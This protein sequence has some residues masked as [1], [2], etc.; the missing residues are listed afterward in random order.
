M[1]YKF[2]FRAQ[3]IKR[4]V[5]VFRNYILTSPWN[6]QTFWFSKGFC[7][8]KYQL[9]LFENWTRAT[10]FIFDLFLHLY[11]L[12]LCP[13]VYSQYVKNS[14]EYVYFLWCNL[15]LFWKLQVYLCII[16][17]TQLTLVPRNCLPSL[18]LQNLS[19]HLRLFNF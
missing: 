14:F 6:L 17:I 11:L 10:T 12:K 3:L 9:N 19:H 7:Y 18:A 4:K 15:I 1:G 8:V 2:K 5:V 13:N 16:S